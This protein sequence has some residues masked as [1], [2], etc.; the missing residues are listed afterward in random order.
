MNIS[1]WF[2]W[3]AGAWVNT[4]WLLLGELLAGKGC[5]ILA[6]KEYASII[7]GDNNC[8]FLYV[9]DTDTPHISKKIDLFLAFDDLAVTKN[10]PIYDL[11][12]IVN[13]KT[14]A[15]KYKNVFS[16]W[17]AV[18]ALWIPKEEGIDL[19]NNRF[20]EATLE[21][22]REEFNAWY[23]YFDTLTFEHPLPAP[24][25]AVAVW[26][27]KTLMF[28]NELLAKGAIE[29]GLDFYSAYPMTPASSIIDVVVQHPDKVTFFQGEDEI[30]VGMSML[31]AKYAGKRAMCG[32]SGWWFALMSE[33]ISF[34]HQAE[35]GGVYVLSQRDWP[36]TGTP[37]FT[38]QGDLLYAMNA[39]FGDTQPI[40]YA[41]STF[42]EMYST[43]GKAL[44]WSDIYQHPVIFLVDKQLS[45]CYKTIEDGALKAEPIDRGVIAQSTWQDD[46]LRYKL[47]EDGIS[48]YAIPG[49]EDMC[50]MCSSYEHTESGETNEEP[51]MK[52]QQME[53]RMKKLETFVAKEFTD[54]FYGYEIINPE[55]KKFF[56]TRGMNRYAIE[57][58][59]QDKPDWWV[60]VVKSFQPFDKRLKEF[61]HS[62]KDAIQKLVFAEM[63]IIGQMQQVVMHECNLFGEERENKISH[64]R[65]YTLYPFFHEEIAALCD[66]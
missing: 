23:E 41:P 43:S 60:V 53:K 66:N 54:E 52:W 5:N 39:T 16:V 27:K 11:K 10:Q 14:A 12:N 19:I 46:Y 48:P 65:K 34:S 42:E 1:I 40:V 9:S 59:I 57:Y 25:C 4:S 22:N 47:T 21:T 18:K 51:T 45:E 8:F 13:V 61:F 36:S 7:K 6:D 44:N 50:F 63:N 62:H 64:T 29:S 3:A 26:S 2:S 15:K 56:V 33:G 31:G 32:T 20:P 17:V 37:T 24:S 30:A 58:A 38:A 28:G 35:I 49:Q 55:A